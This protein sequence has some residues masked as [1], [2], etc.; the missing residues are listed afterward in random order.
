MTILSSILFRM[1]DLVV[2]PTDGVSLKICTV[3][4]I[5]IT[6]YEMCLFLFIYSFFF[7]QVSA[8]HLTILVNF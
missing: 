8:V 1:S 6:I 7:G 4:V 3:S 2:K 5:I